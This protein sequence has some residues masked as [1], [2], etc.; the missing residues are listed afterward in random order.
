MSNGTLSKIQQTRLTGQI[1]QRRGSHE[2]CCN[3]TPLFAL[4]TSQTMGLSEGRPTP[5]QGVVHH[6]SVYSLSYTPIQ[7]HRKPRLARYE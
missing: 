7:K 4:R 5:R 2:L 6:L 1:G 3:A